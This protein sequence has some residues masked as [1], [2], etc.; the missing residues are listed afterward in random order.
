MQQQ[1]T[2]NVLYNLNRN[3]HQQK[4]YEKSLVE[5]IFL[6]STNEDGRSFIMKVCGS[7]GQVYTIVY[8]QIGHSWVCD[9]PDMKVHCKRQACCC[10]H[11]CF[12][13]KRVLKASLDEFENNSAYNSTIS[14]RLRNTSIAMRNGNIATL[15]GAVNE[16]MIDKYQNV[17]SK[18]APLYFSVDSTA[19][20]DK[21]SVEDCPICYEGLNIE[22]ECC[23]CPDCKNVI[24]REC[25]EQWI[26]YNRPTCVYCRS[27][28]W[29][30]F[31]ASNL[32]TNGP[33]KFSYLRI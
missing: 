4:R 19:R 1:T 10:K 26:R 2:L 21:S 22:D 20:L 31:G 24:H 18:S 11:I 16:E 32:S 23:M 33:S 17:I 9:C 14:G 8:D 28:K 15:E 12:V 3:I 7:T 6:L 30:D 25:M 27:I 13:I 29:K 5:R